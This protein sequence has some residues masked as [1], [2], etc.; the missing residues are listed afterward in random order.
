MG[1]GGVR[2]GANNQGRILEMSL[3]QNGDLLKY[4]EQKERLP[5]GCEGWAITNYEAGR[6]KEKG[7]F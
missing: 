4:R 7:G 3:M 5:Q 1:F 2:S 6:D